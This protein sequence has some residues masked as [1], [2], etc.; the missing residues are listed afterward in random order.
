M[1]DSITLKLDNNPELAKKWFSEDKNH[2]INKNFG[3][4]LF[5]N[6]DFSDEDEAE[7]VSKISVFH[8]PE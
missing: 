8:S 7:I 5:A 4:S 1:Y 3:D 2:S 6:E